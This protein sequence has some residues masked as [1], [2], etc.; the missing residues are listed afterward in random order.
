MFS[1]LCHQPLRGLIRRL[2]AVLPCSRSKVHLTSLAVNGLPS[3]HLTPSRNLKLSLV[4]SSFHAHSLARSGTIVLRPVCGLCW[5]YMTRLLKTP[6][7]GPCPAIV[8]SSWMDMLAGLS[9]K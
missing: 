6:C 8:D 2:S 7:A 5:S 3:C 1:T 4:Y 9:K